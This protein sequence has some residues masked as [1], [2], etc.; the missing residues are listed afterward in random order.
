MNVKIRGFY[1]V[2]W[3]YGL[4]SNFYLKIGTRPS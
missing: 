4:K 3:P 1:W 2:K